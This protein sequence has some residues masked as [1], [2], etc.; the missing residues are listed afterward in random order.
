MTLKTFHRSEVMA[1][2][3]HPLVPSRLVID[4]GRMT[5]LRNYGVS[6]WLP[7]PFYVIKGGEEPVLVDTSGPAA[8]MSKLRVEPVEDIMTFE[9][10]LDQVNLKPEQIRKVILTHLMYDHCANAKRLSNATFYTQQ[11][12]LEFA[13]NPHPLYAGVYHRPL[14][15]DLN[16]Q[17]IRG[18]Y[19]LMPGIRL[20]HT[21]GHSPGNQSVAVSTQAG[22]AIITGFCCI[23]ENFE[24][25][26][27]A[28][29]SDQMPEVIPPGIHLDMPQAYNSAKRV[30]DLADILIPMHDPIMTAKRQI[31]E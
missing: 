1:L 13:R 12:E 23:G 17:L 15:E 10:A 14:F 28:W 6:K 29:V 5:Y 19:E 21:P 31:P 20:L 22:M 7:C 27:G 30:A 24:V 11:A 3:I 18:D 16:F 26:D 8:V 9:T 25:K 2:T 4:L